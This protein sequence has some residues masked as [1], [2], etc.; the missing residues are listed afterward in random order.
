MNPEDNGPKPELLP[1]PFCGCSEAYSWG[2]TCG[3]DTPYDP[4][5]RAFPVVRCRSCFCEVPG[6]NWTGE[7]TTIKKWNTRTTPE[8]GWLPIEDAEEE[9]I[10][11]V[12][13]WERVAFAE[14]CPRD[15]GGFYWADGDD[16]GLD[17]TPTHFT[18]I[19]PQDAKEG[20]EG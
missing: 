5:N 1:C 7:E 3:K 18:K 10:L 15:G 14:K 4:S 20:G 12:T 9:I 8:P 11:I 6:E 2:R 19:P 17:W 13:D 16:S